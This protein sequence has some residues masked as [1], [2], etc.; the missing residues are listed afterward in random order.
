VD[1]DIDIGLLGFNYWY[2]VN[3]D[4]SRVP[5]ALDDFYARTNWN[6]VLA[7][8]TAPQQW[9]GK[10]AWWYVSR[11]ATMRS[12]ATDRRE[13]EG[14]KIVILP[15]DRIV[16]KVD[17]FGYPRRNCRIET[18]ELARRDCL[19][20]AHFGCGILAQFPSPV[21]VRYFSKW[22]MLL[23]LFQTGLNGFKASLGYDCRDLV[24]MAILQNFLNAVC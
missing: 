9:T 16:E 17:Q 7:W 21:T 22:C 1:L 23:M 3:Y 2:P 10:D 18:S 6:G 13:R 4:F 5:S 14:R 19:Y 12:Y 15:S 8:Y 11:A 20:D 24:N